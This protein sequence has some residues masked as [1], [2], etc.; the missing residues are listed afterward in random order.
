[1]EDQSSQYQ[2][3]IDKRARRAVRT[4]RELAK[5]FTP[6][7]CPICDYYG[8]FTSYGHPPRIDAQCPK[9]SSMERHRLFWLFQDRQAVI[10]EGD[11]VLH[12]APEKPTRGFVSDRAGTYVTADLMRRDVDLN[13]NVEAMDVADESFDKIVC[14]QV[15]EHV[16][17]QK[18]L[19][20]FHRA[21]AP[22]GIALLNTPVIE[23][24]DKTYENPDVDGRTLRLLHF[25]Q[26]D[27]V[28]YFG[29]DIRDRIR[30]AGFE[31]DEFCAVEPDV[32]DYGL[33]RGERIFLARKAA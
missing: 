5:G 9:C 21:L 6:R 26:G 10:Q 30:A 3:V 13:L 8:M 2:K 11:R 23:G 29:R 32:K 31:C 18:T 20:E 28:R 19:L 25:G 4:Y 1:M 14:F 12:I 27:H 15:L 33:W 17:D 16:D 7:T 22:G 24:W